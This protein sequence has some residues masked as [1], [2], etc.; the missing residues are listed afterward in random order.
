MEAAQQEWFLKVK[1]WRLWLGT[2]RDEDAREKFRSIDDPMAVK[3][4][5]EAL[6]D[7][8]SDQQTR[9]LLIDVLAKIDSSEAARVLAEASLFDPADEVRLVCLDLLQAKKRPDATAYYVGKL[10]D[11][12]SDN[13]LVNLAGFALGRMKDPAA[14]GPLIDALITVHKFKIDNPGGDN[15]T[16]AGFSKGGG[17]MSVGSKPSF[18]RRPVR[19]QSVLDALVSL[20]GKNFDF[21][22]K[23]WKHWYAEQKKA[24]KSLDTRRDAKD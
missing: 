7:K 2:K 19:N 18:E 14:V 12:K 8:Q 4:L 24:P 6:H 16:S 5:A 10:K 15:A 17:G 21:D 11:K 20:T 3:P 22:Q 1:Q 23:A 9:L 13:A